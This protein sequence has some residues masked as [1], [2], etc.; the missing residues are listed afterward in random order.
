MDV[1][2]FITPERLKGS[3]FGTELNYSLK[4]Y[5]GFYPGNNTYAGKRL[6]ESSIVHRIRTKKPG[7][8]SSLRRFCLAL[9][10]LA[11]KRE[12]ERKECWKKLCVLLPAVL[13]YR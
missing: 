3:G 1:C 6:A 8:S 7:F 9:N 2:Y 4:Q 10:L 13:K 12:R 5:T 11:S